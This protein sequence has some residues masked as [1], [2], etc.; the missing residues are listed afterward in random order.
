MVKSDTLSVWSCLTSDRRTCLSY[1]L[2]R[3]MYG[4]VL[5]L[6]VIHVVYV[7]LLD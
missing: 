6:S 7:V 1:N 5:W 3:Y 2:L 4:K